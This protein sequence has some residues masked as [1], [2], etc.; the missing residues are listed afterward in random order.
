MAKKNSGKREGTKKKT[1]IGMS[2]FTKYGHPGAHG[3]NKNYRKRY[4][5]QGR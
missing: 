5:G 3:G 4:R 2:K 1:R